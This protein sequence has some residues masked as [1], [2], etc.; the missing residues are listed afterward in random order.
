MPMALLLGTP[1]NWN[2]FWEARQQAVAAF[3]AATAGVREETLT[4][5]EVVRLRFRGVALPMVGADGRLTMDLRH[6]FRM[7]C[8]PLWE[9]YKALTKDAGDLCDQA[10]QAAWEKFEATKKEVCLPHHGG[11]M[12]GSE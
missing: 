2:I 7:A 11:V 10:V 8:R 9:R 6:E 3:M 5:V 4:A 1:E 12:D